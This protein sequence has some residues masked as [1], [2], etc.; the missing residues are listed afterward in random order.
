MMNTGIGANI[1]TEAHEI[2]TGARNQSYGKV[3]DDYTKVIKIF[4]V[5]TGIELS[6]ADA[7][8]FMVSVKLARLSTNLERNQ[9]HHDSL[10]DALGYLALLNV[11]NQ[12]LPANKL[13]TDRPI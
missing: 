11:A 9:L 7:L 4:Q 3:T 1:L 13:V 8:L 6:Y 2:I 10:L 5:L 12:E